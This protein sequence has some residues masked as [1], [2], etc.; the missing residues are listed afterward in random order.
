[1]K[2]AMTEEEYKTR[3]ILLGMPYAKRSHCFVC[4]SGKFWLDADT[5]EPTSLD[6]RQKRREEYENETQV[7][8]DGK[9]D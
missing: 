6:E 9:D 4:K 5:L 8:D 7:P 3:A 1:M 2:R